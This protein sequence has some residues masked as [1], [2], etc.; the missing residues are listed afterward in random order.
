MRYQIAQ[1]ALTGRFIIINSRDPDLL[2]GGSSWLYLDQGGP[3]L[4]SFADR[5][6]AVTYAT[7]ILGGVK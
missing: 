4:I 5:D 6:A 7:T 3:A 2:W 1:D